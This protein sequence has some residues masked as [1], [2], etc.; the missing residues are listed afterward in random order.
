MTKS[1]PLVVALG[2]LAGCAGRTPPE[3]PHESARSPLVLTVEEVR[4]ENRSAEPRDGT[5]I[6]RRRSRELAE[7]ARSFLEKRVRA[8]GGPGT[9]RVVIERAELVEKPNTKT[10]GI[11]GVFVREPDRVLDATL[12]VRISIEDP[13]GLE[14]AFARAEVA[15]RRAVLEYT[16]I[17]SVDAE[18]QRL[19]E[20]LLAQFDEALQRSAEEN[21]AAFLAF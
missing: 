4:I 13:G 20:D 10:E 19:I 5:F 9:A 6:D 21:L 18:A 17:A 11:L 12:A 7:R 3:F 1:L 8:A 2:L 14:R 15:R 16:D